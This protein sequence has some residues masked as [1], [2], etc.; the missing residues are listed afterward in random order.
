MFV[1]SS[2]AMEP[3]TL[4]PPAVAWPFVTLEPMGWCQ[5]ESMELASV[6]RGCH[7]SP[8]PGLRVRQSRPF[9]RRA[10]GSTPGWRRVRV[11][12]RSLNR[13][14]PRPAWLLPDRACCL[15]RAGTAVRRLA[16]LVRRFLRLWRF[17]RPE[18]TAAPLRSE[19]TAIRGVSWGH[20]SSWRFAGAFPRVLH[21]WPYGTV[22]RRCS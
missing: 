7:F 10:S 20:G 15:P 4:E 22:V 11:R 9:G 17:H 6:F 3:E 1:E 18:P 16:A 13:T 21:P 12:S 8:A 2:R 19:C 14:V 5:Q